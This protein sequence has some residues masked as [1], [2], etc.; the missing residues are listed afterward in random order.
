MRQITTKQS[1][2]T[3]H[4]YIFPKLPL[5]LAHLIPEPSRSLR[6]DLGHHWTSKWAITVHCEGGVNLKRAVESDADQRDIGS[7]FEAG[8]SFENQVLRQRI[9]KMALSV[10][11]TMT[12]PAFVEFGTPQTPTCVEHKERQTKRRK[13]IRVANSSELPWRPALSEFCTGLFLVIILTSFL[14][15]RVLGR[16]MLVIDHTELRQSEGLSQ[17]RKSDEANVLKQD[18]QPIMKESRVLS[19]KR[20]I[21]EW[22]SEDVFENQPLRLNKIHA[23]VPN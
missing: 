7:R 3:Y 19:L 1:S 13:I 16:L 11:S 18:N 22:A 12:G 15:A 8:A 17:Y 14:S 21:F 23:A 6:K 10:K 2:R 4:H 5:K 9:F 20:E